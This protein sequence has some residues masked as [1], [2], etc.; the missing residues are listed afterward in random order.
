[1]SIL[2]ATRSF[3]FTPAGP[4]MA[5]AGLRPTRPQV[6]AAE[7]ARH[8]GGPGVSSDRPEGMTLRGTQ[9]PAGLRPTRPQVAA[10]EEA[11][12][13]GGPGVTRKPRARARGLRWHWLV[14]HPAGLRL[15]AVCVIARELSQRGMTVVVV[16]GAVAGKLVETGRAERS[17]VMRGPERRWPGAVPEGVGPRRRR[18]P[19]EPQ[20]RDRCR[21]GWRLIRSG[22]P[23]CSRLE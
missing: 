8:P 15:A 3:S 7:E 12:H 13:P 5:P 22:L 23:P 17:F 4:S 10:A 20:T 1:M 9:P 16:A 14:R 19:L 6:A 2:A 21:N 11:R 18:F